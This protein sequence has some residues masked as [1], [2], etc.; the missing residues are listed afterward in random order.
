MVSLRELHK[1]LSYFD[2]L[3]ENAPTPVTNQAASH[4]SALPM[5]PPSSFLRPGCFLVSHPLLNDG[6]FNKSVICILKHQP[7]NSDNK[8]DDEGDRSYT[9]MIDSEDDVSVASTSSTSPHDEARG[10]YTEPG[11]TY[12][13]IINRVSI[14][15]ETGRQ[16]T[17]R[18]A[19]QDH[20]LPARLAEVFGNAVVREG[21]PVHVALQMIYSLSSSTDPVDLSM[22][23][24][25]SVEAI[26]GTLIPEITD[27]VHESAALY[28]DRATFFRGNMFKAMDAV[29]DGSLDRDDIS[30]FVGAS[31]WSQGQLA[32]E[33]AQG[34]WRPMR[35]PPEI[36]L[37]GICEHEQSMIKSIESSEGEKSGHIKRPLADLWLSM[38]SACGP[39]D[40]A[41]AHL[42]HHETWDEL[43]LPCDAFAEEDDDDD[44]DDGDDS[45][46]IIMF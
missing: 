10:A 15:H 36:A 45:R 37:H 23:S 42:F 24:P 1:K 7:L 26:G 46:S 43:Q 27:E 6:F 9:T 16:R 39:D 30:F 18:E 25:S 11:Q 2:N 5:S 3:S 28:S 31:T 19:F 41:L 22:S 35:G 12:G 8:E 20:M 40:S 4:V 13:V 29:N 44:D 34:F 32:A 21:G 38:M 33:I 14:N 17:L